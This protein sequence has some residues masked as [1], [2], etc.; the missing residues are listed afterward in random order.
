MRAIDVYASQKTH[1]IARHRDTSAAS[2]RESYYLRVESLFVS[3]CASATLHRHG[4][5]TSLL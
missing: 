3:V 4:E 2:Q 5:V 1:V